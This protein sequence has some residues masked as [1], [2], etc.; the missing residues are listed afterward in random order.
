MS[1]GPPQYTPSEPSPMYSSTPLH[2][3][4]R[5]AHNRRATSSRTGS[6]RR[7]TDKV[8][9]VLSDQLPGRIQPVYGRGGC[10]QG[11]LAVHDIDNII[12]VT[13]R[14]RGEI[15]IDIAST[16]SR[17]RT[18]VLDES[19]TLWKAGPSGPCPPTI[20]IALVWP[21]KFW[22]GSQTRQL[23]PSFENDVLSTSCSYDLTVLLSKRKQLLGLVKPADSVSI[24]LTYFPRTRPPAP[25]TC[26]EDPFVPSM[27][28]APDE[29]HQSQCIMKPCQRS[30]L[31]AVQCS[32]YI[33]IVRV[34]ALSD[35]IPFHVQFHA[36]EAS[37][38]HLRDGVGSVEGHVSVRVYLLRKTSV[39]VNEEIATSRRILG[40][41]QI[42]VTK[43]TLTPQEDGLSALDCDGEVVC[44]DAE[45][46]GP[47][48]IVSNLSV[49]DLIVLEL[50]PQQP[51][52]SSFLEM[53]HAV[54]IRLVT[55]TWAEEPAAT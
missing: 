32:L 47:S 44:G 10:I 45:V 37:L 2:G 28:S 40:E 16:G 18:R 1:S 15:S 14:L 55:D 33:P 8:T 34:Y 50:K 54:P 48:F 7:I 26:R 35:I 4:Q 42:F 39:T 30:A 13:I 49:K 31:T 27:R 17:S 3:E 24:P 43:S 5:V 9:V 25:A 23:P 21:S 11:Y 20:P 38:A 41:G 53:S 46:D 52:K 29:W 22:D 6:F 19:F 36:T 51:L 12:E